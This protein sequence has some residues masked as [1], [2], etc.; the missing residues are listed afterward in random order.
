MISKPSN[1]F[2]RHNKYY[3]FFI[4]VGVFCSCQKEIEI[5]IPKSDPKYVVNCLFQPFNPLYSQNNS[6]S[7]KQSI[8]FLDSLDFP[9]IDNAIVK[10]LGG[11][12]L[13]ADFNYNDSSKLYETKEIP[14][15]AAGNYRLQIECNGDLI[16]AY[17]KLPEKINLKKI[18][19][20]P[21]AGKNVD[22]NS[23]AKVNFNFEDPLDENYYEISISSDLLTEPYSL[24]TEFAGII[25][26]PYYPTVSV[27]PQISLAFLV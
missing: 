11:D 8:G 27:Q 14:S 18:T 5:P 15:F 10:L 17:D 23:Y 13:L 19:I 4:L 1:Y 22:G 26:E 6:V 9:V 7:V 16:E 20:L 25:S 3:I 21:F 2:Y 12:S 24:F